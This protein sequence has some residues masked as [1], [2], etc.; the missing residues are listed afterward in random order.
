MGNMNSNLSEL[1]V[2][3]RSGQRV[4]FNGAKIALAIKLAF[5]DTGTFNSEKDINKIYELVLK[6]I[7]SNYV[8]RKTITVEDIQDIIE[9][10]L[11]NSE[12]NNIYEAFKTYRLSRAA[13]REAF[14]VKQQHKFVKAIETIGL[15]I[16]NSES[17]I[18]VDKISNF[19]EIISDE[20]TRAYLLETKYNRLH[21]EGNIYIHGIPYYA[22]GITSSS[23][24]DFTKIN[25]NYHN[26]YFEEIKNIII[27]IKKEQYGKQTISNLDQVLV[28]PL[29][30]EFNHIYINNLRKYLRLDGFINYIDLNNVIKKIDQNNSLNI[31]LSNFNQSS[32]RVKDIFKIA[33]DDSIIEVTEYL[34]YNLEKLLLELN[35][36]D[37]GIK[38]KSLAISIGSSSSYEGTLITKTY[39]DIL[40]KL[41]R[42]NN[43]LTIYKYKNN[44]SLLL[45]LIIN[46]KNVAI[47]FID[48]DI[49]SN[50]I[51]S[52]TDVKILLSTT[53]INL[54][55]LSYKHKDGNM[56][57]FYKD[58][59]ELMDL[60]KTQ[61]L[62][63]YDLQANMNRDNFKTLFN[64]NLVID[65]KGIERNQKVKKILKNGI[66][67][68]GYIG[69]RDCAET[70]LGKED[71]NNHLC[72]EILSHM[73][74]NIDNYSLD[75]KITFTLSETLDDDINKRLLGIDK[76]IYGI[77]KDK[78]DKFYELKGSVDDIISVLERQQELCSTI[79]II[80]T[81]GSMKKV[82]EILT[83]MSQSK[84]KY[85]R[86]DV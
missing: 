85:G 54:A 15:A 2:V 19:G 22:L 81:K 68:I 74:Q 27:S 46:H 4:N 33:Y 13:S 76:S 40:N 42:L 3:K 37:F 62:L 21:E 34:K 36:I 47:Q 86:I 1:V 80:K 57:E 77:H 14:S 65:D 59:D 5:D 35:S 20:F 6:Y 61:L 56:V 7:E 51:I 53:T 71:T 26:N 73:K 43:V 75:N 84:I 45:P 70:I 63:R 29:I 32:Q 50:G 48:N 78:Y 44:D 79:A 24:L 52:T 69:L 31:D 67:D 17:N 83:V 82:K 18:P 55:R 64:D 9:N 28:K 72:F 16:K 25:I 30:Q 49:Y 39:T 60:T 12:Y 38:D 8:G 23:I 41:D 58:L 10:T 66:L 11:K